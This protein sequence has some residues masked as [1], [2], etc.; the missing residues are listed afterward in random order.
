MSSSLGRD[1]W[2]HCTDDDDKH[3]VGLSS[4]PLNIVV[5]EKCHSS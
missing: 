4:L 3:L 2:I 1:G 5:S